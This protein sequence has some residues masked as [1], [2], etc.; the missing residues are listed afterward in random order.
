MVDNT[1]TTPDFSAL[2]DAI[3]SHLHLN[4]RSHPMSVS[5]IQALA[6][7][8]IRGFRLTVPGIINARMDELRR[9]GRYHY[10]RQGRRYIV[11]ELELPSRP[12]G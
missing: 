9:T 10:S 5:S 2:D 12:L 4:N 6:R 11:P 1:M 3:L 8:H 7:P